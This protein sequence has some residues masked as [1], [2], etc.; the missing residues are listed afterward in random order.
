MYSGAEPQE[1]MPESPFLSEL[2]ARSKD[3]NTGRQGKRAEKGELS[4]Q[5]INP[6]ISEEIF[7]KFPSSPVTVV[8]RGRIVHVPAGEVVFVDASPVLP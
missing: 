7:R 3:S 5:G 4:L 2:A 6:R 1:P 8:A